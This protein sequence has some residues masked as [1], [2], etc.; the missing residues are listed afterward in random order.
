MDKESMVEVT[1]ATKAVVEMA[2]GCARLSLTKRVNI[3]VGELLELSVAGHGGLL[4]SDA[5]YLAS[6]RLDALMHVHEQQ[7]KTAA[8]HSLSE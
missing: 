5:E 3:G 2:A 1:C 6:A 7:H 4:L 8:F